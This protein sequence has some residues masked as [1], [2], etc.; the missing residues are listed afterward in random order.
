MPIK[1]HLTDIR[2]LR[3]EMRKQI[4]KIEKAKQRALAAVSRKAATFISRDIRGTYA[5]RASD[6]K[7]QLSIRKYED[8]ARVLNYTGASL[9]LETFAPKT[10]NVTVT[11]TSSRG[12]RFKTRRRATTVRMR[13]DR[14]RQVVGR[15]KKN[16]GSMDSG[17]GFLAKGR[18]LSRRNELKAENNIRDQFSLIAR[19]GPSIPGMVAYPE[20]I[21]GAEDLIRDELPKEFDRNMRHLLD[22]D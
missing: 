11:A 15:M 17:K 7:A 5:I 21:R 12:K 16:T 6:I 14:G 20:T 18:V 19:Y 22:N 2:R 1:Y 4:P 9:P 10:K 8:T 3:G 13:K